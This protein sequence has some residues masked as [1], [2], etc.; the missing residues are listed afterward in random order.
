MAALASFRN[1]FA[2]QSRGDPLRF[3]GIRFF[4]SRLVSLPL[5]SPAISTADLVYSSIYSPALPLTIGP[6]H[7]KIPQ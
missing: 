5:R 2:V 1:V 3:S 6:N 4:G 7:L